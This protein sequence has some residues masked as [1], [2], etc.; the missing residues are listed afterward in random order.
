MSGPKLDKIFTKKKTKWGKV[1]YIYSIVDNE[2]TPT[3]ITVLNKGE[4]RPDF[5]WKVTIARGK[6]IDSSI[7]TRK[8]RRDYYNGEKIPKKYYKL[9]NRLMKKVGIRYKLE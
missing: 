3:M 2:S 4:K 8:Y 5:K 6:G 1:A 7:T 9:V